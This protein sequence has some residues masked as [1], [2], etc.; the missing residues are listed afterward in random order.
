VKYKGLDL[1]EKRSQGTDQK[2]YWHEK[3]LQSTDQRSYCEGFGEKS[4]SSWAVYSIGLST[5]FTG[6]GLLSFKKICTYKDRKENLFI[7]L[8]YILDIS[9]ISSSF[10]TGR[11]TVEFI[12]YFLF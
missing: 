1:G 9:I 4:F 6:K 2:T 12:Q 10:L 5:F 7:K 3:S 8:T 11:K